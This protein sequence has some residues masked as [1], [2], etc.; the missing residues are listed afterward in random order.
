METL[1]ASQEGQFNEDWFKNQSLGLLALQLSKVTYDGYPEHDQRLTG[2]RHSTEV[3]NA[4][5]LPYG[6]NFAVPKKEIAL[7]TIPE[8]FAFM[9]AGLR[10]DGMGRPLHPWFKEMVQN[11][12]IGVALGNGFYWNYGPNGAADPIMIRRDLSEPHVLLYERN[13]TGLMAIAGGGM[14]EG[15]DKPKETAIREAREEAGIDLSVVRHSILPIYAGTLADVRATAH[16]WPYTTAFA[17]EVDG[18]QITTDLTYEHIDEDDGK[19]NKLTW[20]PQ[21]ELRNVIS[22][23]HLL[24][25]LMALK[26]SKPLA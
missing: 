26:N 7:P 3:R 21:S 17:I 24:L 18:S 11:P 23:S 22:G 19:V 20:T 10:L 12:K 15:D 25:C 6:P 13:D 16:A 14:I 4:L 1:L 9:D 5:D 2:H 8:Q